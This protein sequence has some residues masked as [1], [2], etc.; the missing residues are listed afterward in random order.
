MTS[1]GP[2]FTVFLD[3]NVLA[4]PVT[5]TLIMLASRSSGYGVT[6]SG[7]VESEAD[8]HL[9]SRQRPVSEVRELASQELS[10]PGEVAGRFAAT[11]MSDRQVLAD[12]EEA[13]ASFI[14]TEDVDDFADTDLETLSI[15][16][17][18]PDLFLSSCTAEAGYREALDFLAE[19]SR[20]PRVTSEELH[21]RLGRVHPLT[22][23]AHRAAFASSPTTATHNPPAEMYRGPRCLRCLRTDLETTRLGFCEK[24]ATAGSA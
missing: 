21:S 18:N 13:G 9:R 20:N 7:Y 8:R 6:W 1:N 16:A 23:H 10:K 19:L 15:A 5:R 4:K 22:V 2:S 24:C 17:V 12:A 3:A 14:V 11:S